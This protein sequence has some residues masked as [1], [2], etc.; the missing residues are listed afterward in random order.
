LVV[1]FWNRTYNKRA[2]HQSPFEKRI[3]NNWDHELSLKSLA[4]TADL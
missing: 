2:K 3:R 1:N 4:S